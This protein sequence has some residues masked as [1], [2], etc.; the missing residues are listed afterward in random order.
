[1]RRLVRTIRSAAVLCAALG[2]WSAAHAA[3]LTV[4]QA[5]ELALANSGSAIR[6]E[7]S[8]LDARSGLYG[9]YSSV[10]PQFSASYGR[11]G[12]RTENQT[13]REFF[14][15]FESEYTLEE[16]ERFSTTPQISG[17][18]N[19]LNLSSILSVRSSLS[20][21]RAARQQ[22]TATRNDVVLDARRQ[23]YEVVRNRQLAVVATDAL[24]LARDDERRVRALYDVGSVSRSDLLSAQVRTAQGELDSLT[25]GHAVITQRI[26]LATLLGMRENDMPE[27]DTT[28]TAVIQTFDEAALLTEAAA[29]RPDLKA[30][31]SELNAA[32]SG[33]SAARLGRLPYLTVSGTGQFDSKSHGKTVFEGDSP[34]DT[35][36]DTDRIWS[37]RVALNWDFFDGFSTDA[38]NAAARARYLRAREASDAL[39]RNLQSEVHEALLS[40]RRAVETRR[41]AERA[42]AS[43]TENLKL[44]QQKY[45][46]GAATILELIDA[47]VQ[48]QRARSDGVSASVAILV[49]EAAVERVRGRGE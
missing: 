35:R 5:V 24:R 6:A 25:T 37:G 16:A 10:L 34:S 13:S 33:I 14:G 21:L 45:N 48:L 20:S 38:R 15:G 43:A 27:V 11:S 2:A 1:M 42:I 4:D 46:V 44:T 22:R 9:A 23:F 31:E 3:P 29:N 30:A 19:A 12:T 41:V 32:K 49:A 39:Q 36:S 18:W 26:R 28:L 40:Y 8:V 47:Q 17:S 7:A